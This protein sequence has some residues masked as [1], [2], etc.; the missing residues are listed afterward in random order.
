[1]DVRVIC[2]TNKD[3]EALVKSG[4]F[5]LDLYYRLKGVVIDLPALRQRRNDIPLLVSHFVHEQVADGP[6]VAV[7]GEAMRFLAGYDWPGNIRELKNFVKTIM[8]FHDGGQVELEDILEFKE[9]FVSGGIQDDIEVSLERACACPVCGVD[10]ISQLGGGDENTVVEDDSVVDAKV[11]SVATDYETAEDALIAEVLS[12]GVSLTEL[13]KR[14]ETQS[15][16]KALIESGGNVTKAAELL[17]MKRPRLSQIINA[18]D[19]LSVL[20]ERL[21]S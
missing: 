1:V 4:E 20:K 18:T 9:F 14:I 21:V 7:S 3:L 10:P 15:I 19:E 5:R 17:Q 8:L 2:A 11:P 16:K 6:S 13:K 12:H